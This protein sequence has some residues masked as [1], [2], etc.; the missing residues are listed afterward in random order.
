MATQTMIRVGAAARAKKCRE[1]LPMLEALRTEAATVVTDA[2]PGGLKRY[3]LPLLPEST[4]TKARRG[5][6]CS[7]VYRHDLCILGLR[8]GGAPRERA[9]LMVDHAQDLI[10][11]LWPVEEEDPRQVSIRETEAQSEAEPLQARYQGG[12]DSVAPDLVVRL[13]RHR[14]ALTTFI[15]SLTPRMADRRAS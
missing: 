14:A 13:K 3:T 2:F 10:D 8:K 1:V 6:T 11:R 4:I 15:L 5:Y 7:P 12:D 9:Q